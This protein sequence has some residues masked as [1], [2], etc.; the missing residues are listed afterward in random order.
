MD[1]N[2][3][4]H[5]V[6]PAWC[7]LCTPKKVDPAKLRRPQ[8]AATTTLHGSG[9]HDTKRHYE[10]GYVVVTPEGVRGKKD[11]GGSDDRVGFVHIDGFPNLWLIEWLLEHFPKLHTI[12]T[13]PKMERGLGNKHRR[14]CEARNV[15]LV[16]GHHSP[17]LVWSEGEN[18]SPFYRSQ[19][20]FLLGLQGE[21][22]ALLNELL[23]LEFHTAL[24]VAR[25]FS[26][27]G[28]EF[29]TQRQVA[30]EVDFPTLLQG[31]LSAYINSIFCYLDPTFKAAKKAISIAETMRCRVARLRTILAQAASRQEIAQRLGLEQLPDGLPLSRLD[32]LE[33][34]VSASRK[35]EFQD[36]ALRY[37]REH[38]LIVLRYGLSDGKYRTLQEV[39]QHFG[40]TR[41]RIRQLEERAFAVLGI[42]DE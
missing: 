21:Q 30:I 20:D 4:K 31:P 36:F 18:R 7:S 41:E 22:K 32:L 27:Q 8:R 28:E 34:V 11:L 12:Q 39:G 40:V 2:R 29:K 35:V 15:R 13:T 24:L 19:R 9:S 33:A 26:L 16:L 5:G 42:E 1:S 10:E 37:P 17:N 25:Y 38:K 6:V 23:Q 3:C 14:L